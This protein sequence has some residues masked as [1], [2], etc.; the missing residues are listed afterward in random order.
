MKDKDDSAYDI[1]DTIHKVIGTSSVN[2]EKITKLID[3]F[4]LGDRVY[5]AEQLEFFDDVLEPLMRGLEKASLEI[6]S[7]HI[8]Q[9]TQAPP[10]MLR[11]F[12]MDEFAPVAGP[13]LEFHSSVPESVL[14]EVARTR[15]D[16]HL[17]Y[18]SR[19]GGLSP[20]ITT[21][22]IVR[23]SEIVLS[24]VIE[25][26]TAEFS[27]EG[28]DRLIERSAKV[29]ALAEKLAARLDLPYSVITKL[30]SLASTGIKAKLRS[31]LL[32]RNMEIEAVVDGVSGAV[33]AKTFM[34]MRDFHAAR[35]RVM[36]AKSGKQPNEKDLCYMI[37]Q[38]DVESVI[39]ILGELADL[40]LD[41]VVKMLL[42]SQ[43]LSIVALLRSIGT[44]LETVEK[45][46]VMREREVALAFDRE[47]IRRMFDKMDVKLAKSIVDAKRYVAT[48]NFN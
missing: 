27:T 13:V 36:H 48:R 39:V 43:H 14:I 7:Q 46:M 29:E 12:A 10:K 44:S 23:G 18:L 42:D 2:L 21:H 1:A 15:S 5:S 31:Q 22:L 40:T 25:N 30:V 45:F 19:R 17:R 4:T 20:E 9:T 38:G 26:E 3:L 34:K 33:T 47:M 8:A 41:L 6:L 11:R 37:K 16:A 35:K 32:A 28:L 24:Q